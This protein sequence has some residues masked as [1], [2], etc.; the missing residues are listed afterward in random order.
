[1]AWGLWNVSHVHRL[2]HQSDPFSYSGTCQILS[3]KQTFYL[4]LI[5]APLLPFQMVSRFRVFIWWAY[6][7]STHVLMLLRHYGLSLAL[8][9]GCANQ[10]GFIEVSVI[11]SWRNPI[12]P[13]GRPII[14][15][16]LLF[17]FLTLACYRWVQLGPWIFWIGSTS[18]HVPWDLIIRSTAKSSPWT[19]LCHK[20][21]LIPNL[22]PRPSSSWL[23]AGIFARNSDKHYDTHVPEQEENHNDEQDNGPKLSFWT[24][25]WRF[26]SCIGRVVDDVF[27]VAA[28]SLA[29][30]N[31]LDQEIRKFDGGLPA[32]IR[33]S[34][35]PFIS[36]GPSLDIPFPD[37]NFRCDGTSSLQLI[38][39]QVSHR[40]SPNVR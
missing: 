3:F 6:I 36:N 40:I 17:N 23:T 5:W 1:M 34:V 7:C 30:I 19:T 29:V 16:F 11:V 37:A 2:P 9:W 20:V 22:Q 25:K 28:P 24:H 39:Q 13:I 35:I 27:S 32:S 14:Y 12:H 33:C 26:S 15:P 4:E 21:H 18:S 10:W 31:R 38:M 8:Q